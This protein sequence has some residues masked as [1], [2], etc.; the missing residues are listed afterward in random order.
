MLGGSY[1]GGP[2]RNLPRLSS[3]TGVV[4]VLAISPYDEDHASLRNI[5][6]HTKWEVF[7]ARSY[8]EALDFLA[9]NRIGVLL[10]ES[11]LPDGT[12]KELQESLSDS[13]QPPLLIVTSRHA[14]DGL[15]AEVL[16]LGAYDVVSKPFEREEVIR[17][18]SLAWL[19]WK[20]QMAQKAGTP[21]S[22]AMDISSIQ[23][24]SAAV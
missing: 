9:K 14:D 6:S 1:H 15:W 8:Q 20:E 5:F 23:T 19:H 12:W 18:I 10:C 3:S 16:N 4:A 7:E 2:L 24:N 11:D 17:I 21:A 13:L 22:K